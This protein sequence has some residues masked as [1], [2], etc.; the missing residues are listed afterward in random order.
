MGFKRV[1]ISLPIWICE[2]ILDKKE[3]KS[4]YITKCIIKEAMVIKDNS[5]GLEYSLGG[6][7][8]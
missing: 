6:C 7:Y 8:V 2:E 5:K 1:N 3:N 4:A